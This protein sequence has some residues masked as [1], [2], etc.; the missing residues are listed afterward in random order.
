MHIISLI[1]WPLILFDFCLGSQYC[2]KLPII[3]NNFHKQNSLIVNK[4]Y[5]NYYENDCFNYDKDYRD[6]V[7]SKFYYKNWTSQEFLDYFTDFYWKRLDNNVDTSSNND[8]SQINAKFYKKIIRFPDVTNQ[9]EP[10]QQFQH[11]CQNIL[12]LTHENGQQNSKFLNSDLAI[13]KNLKEENLINEICKDV[14]AGCFIKLSEDYQKLKIS[15]IHNR[16]KSI[17]ISHRQ[18]IKLLSKTYKKSGDARPILAYSVCQSKPVICKEFYHLDRS[19]K[20][21]D[22][23]SC[24]PNI[25]TCNNGQGKISTQGCSVHDIEICK[26][27]NDGYHLKSDQLCYKNVCTCENGEPVEAGTPECYTD[28]ADVC[29]SCDD[30]KGYYLN[31]NRCDLKICNCGRNGYGSTGVDCPTNAAFHCRSCKS[32]YHLE[33]SVCVANSCKCDNGNPVP[34]YYCANHNQNYCRSCN[35]GYILNGADCQLK[36]CSCSQGI[37]A[38]G[39]DCPQYYTWSNPNKC[40]SCNPPSGTLTYNLKNGYC[41]SCDTTA[42]YWDGYYCQLKTC[43]CNNGR[44]ARGAECPE[45]DTKRCSSCN[46]KYELKNGICKC[47]NKVGGNCI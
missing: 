26:S 43:Y 41:Y 21:S 45:H 27:C 44:N 11:A 46:N 7:R 19:E 22:Y 14:P 2:R 47:K 36:Q 40:V 8:S 1:F 39:Y 10:D 16:E 37:A 4:L 9:T 15:K 5:S 13:I 30:S 42:N 3:H 34:S 6:E 28:G 18:R 12:P 35:S 24:L 23:N 38:T 17:F 33:G 29:K 25:C 31:K 20:E 32:Y